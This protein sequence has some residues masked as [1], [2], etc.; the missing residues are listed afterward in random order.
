MSR[1]AEALAWAPHADAPGEDVVR[2]P[3]Y[4]TVEECVEE[5]PEGPCLHRECRYHLAHRGYWDHQLAPNRDCS[6]DVANEGPHTIDEVA[7][8]LGMSPER[9]RQLEQHAFESLR[10]E[11]TLREF[12]EEDEL[13]RARPARAKRGKR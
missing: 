13:P 10:L 2:L 3:R 8:A 4:P 12:Y 11:P 6:L 9:V 5:R 1:A 7:G